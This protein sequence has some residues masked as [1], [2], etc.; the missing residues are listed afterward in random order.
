MTEFFNNNLFYEHKVY[1]LKAQEVSEEFKIIESLLLNEPLFRKVQTISSILEIENFHLL[2]NTT[3]LFFDIYSSVCLNGIDLS[4]STNLKTFFVVDKINNEL[5]AYS[6]NGFI[7]EPSFEKKDEIFSFLRKKIVNFEKIKCFELN[8]KKIVEQ[9]KKFDKIFELLSNNSLV[10]KTDKNGII[11]YANDIFLKTSGYKKTEI[12]GK[13]H[14]LIR[15]P[16]TSNFEIQDMWDSIKNK[17]IWSGVVRNISKNGTDYV[18]ESKIIPEIDSS[19]EIIGFLAVQ[20]DITDLVHKNELAQLLINEQS[21]AILIGQVGKG[22]ISASKEFEN[23]FDTQI[24]EEIYSNKKDL[25]DLTTQL[26]LESEKIKLFKEHK[27]VILHNVEFKINENKNIFD[28]IQ[29]RIDSPIGKYYFIT[30]NDITLNQKELADAK[31][32]AS[33]KSNFLATMSHEIRTPLNGMIPYVELLLETGDFTSEQLEYIS[34]IK[35]SSESLL[36]IINDILDFSKI[37][38][39]KLEIENISFDP[40][41][42]FETVVDLYTAKADEKGIN[43]FTYIE[44]TLPNLIGDPLRI[45]Q[46]INN[47]LSNAIKFTPENGEIVF[48]V[49]NISKNSSKRE[50]ELNI[51]IK[52]NGRGIE[53]EQQLN[54]FT[55]FSQADNSISRK[56]GGTGLGL[57][58]SQNLATSM[59]GKIILES[60]IDKGSKFSLNL[61]LNIDEK[62]KN[63]KYKNNSNHLVGIFTTSKNS[64][65]FETVL[66]CKYLKAMGFLYKK[67]TTP[68]EALNCDVIFVMSSGKDSIEF[69]NESFIRNKKIITIMGST[70]QNMNKYYS[71]AIINMPINGSKIFDAINDIERLYC[72]KNNV[73]N[74]TNGLVD[75]YNA[76]ILVAEDNPTNQKLVKTLL[77]KHGIQVDIAD[78]GK[79]ALDKYIAS[80]QKKSKPYDLIFMDIHMPIMDGL[81]SIQKIR[82]IEHEKNL[83]AINIIALTADAIKTHQ[84]HYLENGFNDFLAKPIEKEKF[85]YMLKKY[86]IHNLIDSETIEKHTIVPIANDN[87]SI[88]KELSQINKIKSICDNLGLDVETAQMLLDDFMENWIDFKKDLLKAIEDKNYLEIKS[89]SHS[90]K[91]ASGSLQLN[92]V[93]L[94][95][96]GLEYIAMEKAENEDISTYRE[97][98]NEIKIKIEE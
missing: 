54:I 35:N 49:E 89:I 52:D 70:V 41:R 59:G 77:V 90:L 33:V 64:F 7:I 96:K 6:P 72:Y 67:I 23:T 11:I 61:K 98:F 26:D 92:D 43:L 81:E 76:N 5:F 18:V 29:K 21:N 24:L 73:L 40:I 39:G 53:E 4:I 94:A 37:E 45:K 65:K 30:L 79:I 95:C 62:N 50:I 44:P 86:L 87:N 1:L 91:G 51:Q 56:Y 48:Y 85:E 93:Y 78:N 60:K 12:I 47:L 31:L 22:I 10:T 57:S 69:I 20:Y 63:S 84:Q 28:V 58:I 25:L 42:E 14:S 9:Q 88:K 83:T 15:H 13:T 68:N 19:G 34:T 82:T 46:I 97:I 36:R 8:N 71:H 38:S 80:I 74:H 2:E 66:L 3:L 16:K 17:K 75:K 32:E 55:P 27:N